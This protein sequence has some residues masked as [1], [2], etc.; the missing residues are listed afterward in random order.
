[1]TVSS[2]LSILFAVG[3]NH[4]L[5]SVEV[6]ERLFIQKEEIPSLLQQLKRT[7][8][9]AVVVSTC[10]RTEVYAVTKR[11]DIPINYYKDLLINFKS[12]ADAVSH[13]NF[14]GLSSCTASRQLFRVATGVDSSVIGDMQILGQVREAYEI[15]RKHGSVGK[16]LHQLFQRALKIGKKVRTDTNFQRGVISISSASV[17]LACQMLGTLKNSIALVIGAGEM[18]KQTAEM[19]IKKRVGKLLITNRTERNGLKLIEELNSLIEKLGSSSKVYIEFVPFD[20]YK[21]RLNEVDVLFTATSAPTTILHKEDFILNP[22][23]GDRKILL[24]DISVPRNICPEVGS[25]ENVILKNI[26]DLKKISDENYQRRIADLPLIH[27]IIGKELSE[28]LVW[29]YSLPFLPKNLA[30]GARPNTDEEL[31]I[32]QTRK[33]LLENIEHIHKLAMQY[34]SEDLLGQIEIVNRLK[35]MRNSASRI[36]A[37]A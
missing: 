36:R 21:S 22:I 17:D 25:C 4:K 15:A 37:N 18:A 33:F 14:F 12:A 8:D 26:D 10:N 7:V 27:E 23:R 1:V 6:L 32:I 34:D 29:Y 5:A 19:L 20:E 28:F 11:T 31:Q 3:I 30:D 35:S 2:E 24:I 16:I 13:E 9:E